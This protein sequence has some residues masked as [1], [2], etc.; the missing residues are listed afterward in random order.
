MVYEIFSLQ[1]YIWKMDILET[2]KRRPFCKHFGQFGKK[3]P[4]LFADSVSAD[5]TRQYFLVSNLF[6]H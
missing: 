1:Q 5:W 4:T 6:L 3:D 2:Y